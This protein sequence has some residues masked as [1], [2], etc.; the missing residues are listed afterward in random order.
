MACHR[1]G[2][3]PTLT[4]RGLNAFAQ[5]KSTGRSDEVTIT[6]E[7]ER[8]SQAEIDCRAHGAKRY[9]HMDEWNKMKVDAENCLESYCFT[10]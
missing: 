6:N 8:E 1:L 4:S 5:D 9:Q 3:P 2:L 7:K 10:S